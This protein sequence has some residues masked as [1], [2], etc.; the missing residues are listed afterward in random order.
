M[1]G[2][3]CNF[4]MEFT[5]VKVKKVSPVI[6]THFPYVSFRSVDNYLYAESKS[7][8]GV[9]RWNYFMLKFQFFILY[10]YAAVKKIDADWLSG[11]PMKNLANHWVFSPFT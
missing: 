4:L 10:F 5:M 1:L 9:P 8:E 2:N 7:E 3:T 11:Y 6:L